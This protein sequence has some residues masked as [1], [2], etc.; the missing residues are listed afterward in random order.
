MSARS[1]FQ[2]PRPCRASG[3]TAA[4]GQFV[5]GILAGERTLTVL[6]VAPSA[7]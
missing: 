6:L 4:T 7:Q 5:E 1:R 3:S 2:R